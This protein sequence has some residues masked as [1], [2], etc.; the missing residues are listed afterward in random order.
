MAKTGYLYQRTIPYKPGQ[1]TA[2]KVSRS[3][4]DLFINCPACFWLDRRLK[5]TRPDSPPFQIN[6]AVDELYKK[7]F[8]TYRKQA[9]PHPLML[10][11]KIDAIPFMHED[12]DK[13]RANFTGVQFLHEP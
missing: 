7:E 12:L 2:F 5:I 8:D 11:Y 3:K 10:E 13:W 4:I 1:K 9:E 6:K